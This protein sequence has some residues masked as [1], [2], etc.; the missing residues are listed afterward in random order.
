MKRVKIA[1]IL[2]FTMI[3]GC[4]AMLLH[5]KSASDKMINCA[6]N[7]ARYIEN[8][9]NSSA[10]GELSKLDKIWQ[11]EKRFFHILSGGENCEQLE[12]SLEQVK[13]WIRQKEK[14]PETL[15]ELYGFILNAEHLWQTQSPGLM[16]LL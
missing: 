3:L 7:T 5:F 6:N 16:N 1:V 15:S 4:S 11:S 8:G 10:M 12:A 14:S 2:L 13:V 9:D